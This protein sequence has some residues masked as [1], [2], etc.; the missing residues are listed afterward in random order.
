MEQ[1]KKIIPGGNMLISKNPD[2]FLPDYWPTYFKS[3]KGC[4][5]KDLDGN[6]F[7]DFSLMGIGTNVLGYGNPKVDN[8]VKK[9]INNGPNQ[10]KYDYTYKPCYK[11]FIF[12]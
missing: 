2:R 5:I 1:C 8:A 9:T 11:F 10:I 4:K 7:I 6:Q 3:A 12:D